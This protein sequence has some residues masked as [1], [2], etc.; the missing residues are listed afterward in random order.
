MATAKPETL[1]AVEFDGLTGQTIIRP[2]TEE[3]I[4]NREQSAIQSEA[5]LAAMQAR[6]AARASALAKLAELG[7]TEAE[8]NAL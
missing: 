2:L 5:Q 3:E 4:I 6:A 1:N 7:L 8:I